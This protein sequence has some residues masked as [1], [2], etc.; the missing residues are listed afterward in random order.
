MNGTPGIASLYAIQ[1]GVEI[2]A[3]VGVENI[4][5]KS[6][7]QTRLL[8]D[9][10]DKLGYAVISPRDDEYRAGTV[11]VN[12]PYAYEVSRELLARNFI[13]DFR[14]GAGIRLA[15]HFY[16]SD[17]ELHSVMET[18]TAILAEG[19]WQQHATDRDFV[20]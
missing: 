1:P 16:T 9:L 12:P 2:I 7:H 10:A 13:V 8:I 18:I 11:T 15:P 6:M 4:R 5:K 17:A 14:Q 3:E 19:S 20:T